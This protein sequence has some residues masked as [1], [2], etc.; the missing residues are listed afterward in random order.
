MS[1]S[2]VRMATTCT[3]VPS[4][5]LT[6]EGLRKVYRPGTPRQVVAVDGVDLT[7]GQGTVLGLLG[8]NGAGKTTIIKCA[9]GLIRPTAGAVRI[10]GYDV[11]RQPSQA[12]QLVGAVLEGSRNVYWRLTVLENLRFFA[13]LHGFS[14]R[15]SRPWAEHLLDRLSLGERRSTVVNE[16]SRGMQQK[17]AVAC[18]LVRRS[19][20]LLL[21]EPTLGLDVETARQLEQVL[22]AIAREEGSTVILSSHQMDLVERVCDRVAIIRQGRLVVDDTVRNLLKL[23]E[24]RSYRFAMETPLQP[25]QREA[26]EEAFPRAT[27][28]QDGAG[29]VLVATAA[30]DFYRLMDFLRDRDL[31]V[32]RIDRQDPDLGDIFLRIVK[33]KQDND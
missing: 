14:W 6:I 31:R 27:A 21:D 28:E 11:W 8:P 9:L 13:S 18:A 23:F 5:P 7:V 10:G 15:D 33:E 30:R 12:R 19:P 1:E 2:A 24:A 4:T 3:P 29:F 16:L 20:L 25:E 17:V 32:A 22:T 26:L